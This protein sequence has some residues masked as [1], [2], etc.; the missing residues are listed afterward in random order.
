[1]QTLK[2][3]VVLLCMSVLFTAVAAGAE[4]D[5]APAASKPSLTYYYFDG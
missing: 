1:M 2:S 4:K 3:L 5:K